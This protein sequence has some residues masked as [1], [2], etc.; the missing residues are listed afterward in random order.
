M[1]RKTL[2]TESK[3]LKV[4]TDKAKGMKLKEI[5][6][7]H[8]LTM[9]QVSYIVYQTQA[10]YEPTVIHVDQF[11]NKAQKHEAQT[12]PSLWERIKR[13]FG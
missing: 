7:K 11:N 12:Q 4:R 1:A 9:N 10:A 6:K 8:K 13:W 3:K 5:A 2:F